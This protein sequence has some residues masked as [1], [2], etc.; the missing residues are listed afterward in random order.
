[1]MKSCDE[2]V[3]FTFYSSKYVDVHNV[4]C[5]LIATKI[6][7]FDEERA[8]TLQFFADKGF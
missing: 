6:R 1:M 4:V 3:C 5:H 2:E 8:Q 7:V